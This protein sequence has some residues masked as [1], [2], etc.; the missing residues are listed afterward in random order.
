M[1]FFLKKLIISVSLLFY[2]I[3]T[4]AYF[5]V[6]V[7]NSTGQTIS[8]SLFTSQNSDYSLGNKYNLDYKKKMDIC[9]NEEILI[10]NKIIRSNKI[11]IWF[12]LHAII[13]SEEVLLKVK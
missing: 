10:E 9:D 1:K 2:N 5:Q 8:Y 12:D 4:H 7:I 11:N 6:D 3:H 13:I